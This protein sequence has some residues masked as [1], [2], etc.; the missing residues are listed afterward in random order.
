MPTATVPSIK[1]IFIIAGLILLIAAAHAPIFRAGFVWDDTAL[2]L[3]DPLIRSWRLV[4]EG[5]QHFLFIDATPSNFFRPLQRLSYTLEYWAFALRPPGYHLGNLCLHL[6]AAAVLFLFTRAFLR[7]YI[8]AEKLQLAIASA[9]TFAWAIHPVHS[10]VVDYVSGCADS[11]AAIFGFLALY[12]T[13]CAVEVPRPEALKFHGLAGTALLA[14]GL[15]KESGLIFIPLC[16]ALLFLRKNWRDLV[17]SA[18]AVAFTITIY[19]TLRLQ[20]G[21]SPLP[22]PVTPVPLLARPIIAARALAE[23]AGLVAFPWNLH[24][25][26]DVNTRASGASDAGLTANAWR[27]LE[28]IAGVVLLI[29]LF[30]WIK[31]SREREPCVFGLL[32]FTVISYLPISGLFSLN[33]TVAEHWIYVPS[34]FFLAALAIEY[35]QLQLR[36]RRQMRRTMIVFAL[37][38]ITFLGVRTFWRTE[39]WRDQRTF[40]EKTIAAGGDSSRML[41]NL[42]GLE[43]SEGNLDRADQLLRAVLAREPQ[44]PFALLNL[45]AVA[46]KKHDFSHA[47]NFAERALKSPFTEAQAQEMLAI[48]EQNQTGQLNLIRLRLASRTT[49]CTWSIEKRYLRAL[50]QSGNTEVAVTELQGL[51]RSDWFRAESWKLLQECLVKLGRSGEAMDALSYARLYDVHLAEYQPVI[52]YLH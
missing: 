41:I 19:L 33:A 46:V 6:A 52:S 28:T 31:R 42:G 51:L 36:R 38:W 32:L 34:A 11:L 21:E 13:V 3:R 37:V 20:A 39:D 5:F 25:E 23:Y 12:F 47:R 50:E 27:E 22:R 26:R 16:L 35:T 30:L 40:L 10:P 49:P 4:P 15:S 8:A 48:V 7:L 9:A 17:P 29:G 45:A 24:V 44:Q 43:M 2:I 1:R 14:A 18:V